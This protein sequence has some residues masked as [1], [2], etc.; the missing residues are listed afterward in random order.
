MIP[1]FKHPNFRIHRSVAR[2]VLPL[3]KFSK[4]PS[5]KDKRMIVG[6]AVARPGELSRSLTSFAL[7]RLT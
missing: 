3:S 5:N 7:S 6:V 1:E 2:F 4:L